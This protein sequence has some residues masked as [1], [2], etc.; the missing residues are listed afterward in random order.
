MPEKN[1]SGGDGKETNKMVP[2]Y[3][4]QKQEES[5]TE[6]Q[7]T[8]TVDDQVRWEDIFQVMQDFISYVIYGRNFFIYSN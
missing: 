1:I 8:W 3:L 5:L 2:K 4:F 6:D 7:K